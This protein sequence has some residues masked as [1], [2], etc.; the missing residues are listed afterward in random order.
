MHCDPDICPSC[1]YIGEG[2]SWCEVTGEIVL[3]DWAPTE[4]YM[5]TG[6]PY[7]AARRRRRRKQK[8]STTDVVK[9]IQKYALLMVAGVWLYQ[10]GAA[11]A[12][13]Q[14]GYFAI[15]GEI[16]ALLLPYFYWVFSQVFR[17]VIQLIKGGDEK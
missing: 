16:L 8:K 6:C 1:Q 17:S 14:R 13:Q 5:G 7:A 2:D 9:T 4:H 10:C 12:F 15:G 3:S 11:Y